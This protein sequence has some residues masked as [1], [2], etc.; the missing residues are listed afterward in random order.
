[1]A[2]Y[3][4]PWF[5]ALTNDADPREYVT[6]AKPTIYRAHLVYRRLPSCFDVVREDACIGQYAGMSGAKGLIDLIQ[7]RPDDFWAKR[8]LAN[9]EGAGARS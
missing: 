3:R 1:M 6:D 5:E 2:R 9:L 8:A 7:D 4:N